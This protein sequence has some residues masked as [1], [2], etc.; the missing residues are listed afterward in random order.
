MIQVI[1][2]IL[3]ALSTHTACDLGTPI[4]WREWANSAEAETAQRVFTIQTPFDDDLGDA[5]LYE[6][7]EH[8]YILFVFRENVQ[9]VLDSGRSDPHGECA[10]RIEYADDTVRLSTRDTQGQ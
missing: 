10:V 3:L 1:I 2:A 6:T 9:E 4:D 8:S 7:P 5:W